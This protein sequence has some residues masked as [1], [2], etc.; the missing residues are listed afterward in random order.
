MAQPHAFS[1]MHPAAISASTRNTTAAPPPTVSLLNM[2]RPPTATRRAAS[3]SRLGA[4]AARIDTISQPQVNATAICAAV[5]RLVGLGGR[6][7]LVALEGGL[8][9]FEERAAAFGEVGALTGEQPLVA[10]HRRGGAVE[11]G[12]GG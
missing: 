12:G 1:G 10:V 6:L 11:G 8:A 3:L 7:N 9:L 2:P 4:D 5:A